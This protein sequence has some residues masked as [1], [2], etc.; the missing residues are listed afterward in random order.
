M[1][2]KR[3]LKL[4][5]IILPLLLGVFVIW[6]SLAQSSEEERQILWKNIKQANW[7]WV[8]LSVLFGLLSHLSRAFRWRYLLQPLDCKPKFY[9]SFLGVMFGYLSNMGIPR[10]G[11]FL[12][13]A[14]MSSY[15]DISFEKSFGTIVTERIVD[16]I[17]MSGV[18]ALAVVLHA[19]IM[20]DF[21]NEKEISPIK[22]ISIL[23]G[24][25]IIGLIFLRLVR[26]SK[27]KLFIK[28]RDFV[29]G[30][31]EGMKSV[32]SMKRKWSFVLHTVSIWTMYFMAFYVAKF[33]IPEAVDLPFG[34]ILLAFIAGMFS[35]SITSGGIG[36][37]PVAVGAVLLL[38][39][40]EKEAGEALG[41]ILWTTQ[42]ILVIVIGGLASVLLPL[43]NRKN[44]FS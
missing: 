44:I 38:F 34:A 9:N 27:I 15:E 21:I 22:T 35:Y 8:S 33:S 20:L 26:H 40:L 19:D 30:L 1:T 14:T 36:L 17:S 31:L 12:R 25:A 2:I 28:I 10:S 6:Y 7:F 32:F 18:I 5:K 37:Y 4:A 16:L 11:E 13:G 29:D 39:D 23:A 24:L 3:L 43:L 41:W 42:T